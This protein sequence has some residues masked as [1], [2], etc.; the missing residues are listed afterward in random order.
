[1]GYGS[2]PNFLKNMSEKEFNNKWSGKDPDMM[3]DEQLLQFKN[4]CFDLYEET[5][6]L[7]VFVSPN[8]EE[9]DGMPIFVLRRATPEEVDIKAMPIWKVRF[10]N[11]DEAFCHPEEITILEYE[12][13]K[14]KTN[15]KAGSMY[16]TV[17]IDYEYPDDA[18]EKEIQQQLM[19]ECDYSFSSRYGQPFRITNTEICGQNTEF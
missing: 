2:Q 10:A 12:R 4:D 16:I 11:G 8:D 3:D 9:H 15:T 19:S 13:R 6:F 7:P 14:P 18:D 5:G 1:M 17:R